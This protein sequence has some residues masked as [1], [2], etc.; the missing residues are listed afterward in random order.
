MMKQATEILKHKENMGRTVSVPKPPRPPISFPQGP[1]APPP[2]LGRPN[3][4]VRK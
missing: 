3:N 2:G 4:P 1:Y